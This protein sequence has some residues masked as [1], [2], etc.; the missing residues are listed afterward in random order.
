[1]K[2][3]TIEQVKKQNWKNQVLSHIEFLTE[4]NKFDNTFTSLKSIVKIMI[5]KEEK[6]ILEKNIRIEAK[7]SH[8]RC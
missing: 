4:F 2:A 1:M 3:L 6:S 7:I 8:R 5:E